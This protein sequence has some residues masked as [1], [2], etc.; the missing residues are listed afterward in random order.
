MYGYI[1]DVIADKGNAVYTVALGVTVRDAVHLMNHHH[2]GAL[3]V[4]HLGSVAGIFTERDVLLRVVDPGID[5]DTTRVA[6]VM[7]APV[8]IVELGTSVADAMATMTRERIRHLPVLADG[9]LAGMIS[10]GDLLRQVTRT[11]EDSI[12]RMTDYITGRA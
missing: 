1:R 8:R 9:Q 5:P 11:Q 12:V 7:S 3:V 4:Y 2:V 10:I 6:A